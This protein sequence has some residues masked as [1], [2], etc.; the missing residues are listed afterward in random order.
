MQTDGG[1]GFEKGLRGL[2][3]GVGDGVACEHSRDFVDA[4]GGVERGDVA[5]GEA[6]GDGFGDLEVVCAPCRDLGRMRDDEDLCARGERGQ[7]AAN[8]VGGGAAHTAVDLVEY[9]R[10]AAGFAMQADL[11]RQQEPAELAP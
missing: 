11:E 8:G 5:A 9:H 3:R 6:I 7:T 4:G 1:S 10:L 2:A